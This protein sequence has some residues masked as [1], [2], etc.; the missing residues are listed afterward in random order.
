[1]EQT[2]V[3]TQKEKFLEEGEIK[4]REK[5]KEKKKNWAPVFYLNFID[6]MVL[7]SDVKQSEKHRCLNTNHRISTMCGDKKKP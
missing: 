7:E 2:G 1:M 3:W 6:D 5:K 4:G